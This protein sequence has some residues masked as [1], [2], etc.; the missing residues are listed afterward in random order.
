M[1]VIS[2]TLWL[3]LHHVMMVPM[4]YRLVWQVVQEFSDVKKKKYLV[5]GC[6]TNPGD[7]E[8]FSSQLPNNVKVLYNPEF[9]AQGSIV[10]DLKHIDMVLL[11][12][13]EEETDTVRDIEDLYRKIQTTRSPLFVQ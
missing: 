9:I 8:R 6:T 7:C 1:S 3:Q 4:M 11:G 5:V 13:D 12:V 2:S 10:S